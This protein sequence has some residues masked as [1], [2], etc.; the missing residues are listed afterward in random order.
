MNRIDRLTAILIHLQ[1][2]RMVAA[3]EISERFGIS[4]R[5]V[6]RDIRALEDA[7]VPIGA[8]TGKGYFIVEGYHLPPVMFT[9][10]EAGALLLGAKLVE[11]YS[12]SSVKEHFESSLYKIKS[13]LK[14]KDKDYLDTL[15]AH[16]EV[17]DANRSR[18]EGFPDNFLSHIQSLVG[19]KKVI[20]INYHS[21]YKNE[22]TSRLIEPIGLCFYSSNW[23][24]IAYCRLRKEYR[25]FRVDRIKEAIATDI[26]FDPNR[27]DSLQNLIQTIVVSEDLKPVT[28]RFHKDVGHYIHEDKHYHGF[29]S[30]K[31]T[32]THFEMDFMVSSYYSFANWLFNFEE[33]AEVISPAVLKSHIKNR[34][35]RLYRH[36]L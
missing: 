13:V 30:Q 29:V 10:D 7:G 6:Y 25:D 28:V 26:L 8:E 1:T 11:K 34:L 4:L 24:L 21:N 3:K 32:G 19:E 23:H 18:R 20:K 36:Y 35:E 9:R 12:D 31:D 27:H 14:T 22:I 16:I 15:D 33:K 5:T 17:L 2:K